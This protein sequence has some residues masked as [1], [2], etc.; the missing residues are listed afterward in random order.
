MSGSA[1]N[2]EREEEGGIE[3]ILEEETNVSV[4]IKHLCGGAYPQPTQPG[5]DQISIKTPNRNPKCRLFLKIDQ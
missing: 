5:M 2:G 4:V 1:L 3:K